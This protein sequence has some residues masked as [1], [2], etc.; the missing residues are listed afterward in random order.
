MSSET[1][2]SAHARL[3][4]FA[5]EWGVSVD[6]TVETQSSLIALGARRNE[7]IAMKTVKS[8]GDEW[9]AA[10]VLDAFHGHG[11]VRVLER[12]D[13]A[14]LLERAIPGESL[15]EL[16]R[17]GRD[18]EAI[19]ILSDIMLRMSAVEPTLPAPTVGDWGKGFDRYRDSGDGRIPRALVVEAAATFTRLASSQ[20][21]TRLLHGDLHHHNVLRDDRRGWLAIDPKGVIGEMEYEIGAALRNPAQLPSLFLDRKTIQR[22]VDRFADT[23]RL[24]HARVVAWGF[25]QAVLSAVWDIED[26]CDVGPEHVGLRLAALMQPMLDG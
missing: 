2:A 25:A 24:D 21:S 26:G 6:E 20:A 18:D 19:D 9:R 17:L 22:R 16:S 15:V 1:P 12:A 11:T 10:D 23:L 8:P 3:A 14:A 5:R 7:P 13:G 4:H